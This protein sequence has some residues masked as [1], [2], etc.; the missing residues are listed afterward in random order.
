[1][2]IGAIMKQDR[3]ADIGTTILIATLFVLR[4]GIVALTMKLHQ[5]LLLV[6]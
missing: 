2:L 3:F 6:R 1:M 4:V 5:T